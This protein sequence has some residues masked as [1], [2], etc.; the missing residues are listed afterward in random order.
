MSNGSTTTF[1]M[2]HKEKNKPWAILG[3][4]NEHLDVAEV[5]AKVCPV[6]F[7]AM[8]ERGGRE[9]NLGEDIPTVRYNDSGSTLTG[10]AR[11]N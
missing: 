2:K 3:D 10:G 8:E 5:R 7:H 4:G 11:L 9:V 6:K 1:P